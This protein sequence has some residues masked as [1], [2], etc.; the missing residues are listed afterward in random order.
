MKLWSRWLSKDVVQQDTCP[1]PA[2]LR[3]I[4]YLSESI[5]ILKLRFDGPMTWKVMQRSAWKDTANWRTKQLNSFSKLQEDEEMGSV[6]EMSTIC[7]HWQTRRSMV[8]EQT[9][10]CR[11]QVDQSLWQTI[12]SFD[13]LHTSHER[14]QTILSCGNYSTTIQTWIVSRLWFLQETLKTQNQHQ[15]DP[16]AYSVVIHLFH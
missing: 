13:V 12:M 14:I 11:H 6:G 2:E 7:S 9:C 16:Y 3:L 10:T 5:L 8:R 4:G 1:E 15:E